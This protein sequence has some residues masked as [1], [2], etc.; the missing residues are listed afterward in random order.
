MG[1]AGAA[2]ED[3]A[4]HVHRTPLGA[5]TCSRRPGQAGH[6]PS[7]PGRALVDE[8]GVALEQVGAGLQAGPR[9]LGG[10]R[11]RRRRPGSGRGPRARAAAA[12]PRSAARR[13]G[14][15][16]S[17]A[18][19][20]R[21]DVGG[22]RCAGASREIVVLVATMPSRPRARARSATASTSSSARSG[23]ILTSSGTRPAG[24]RAGLV[25]DPAH[26]RRS[27]REALDGLQVAQARGVRRGDVDDEVVGVRGEQPGAG[28][29]VGPT[30][31][32]RPRAPPWSCRC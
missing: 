25:G 22:R 8:G 14:G 7:G 5:P 15:P 19:A 9:V 2:G 26:G 20:E 31:P 10:G 12:A 18:G 27:G 32:G 4:A 24:V 6:D 28:G 17:A 11:C 21:L 16:E 1:P 30:R 29:V 3:L 23:A 13:S